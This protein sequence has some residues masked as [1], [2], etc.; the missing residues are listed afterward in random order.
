ME[1]NEHQNEV[2]KKQ[3]IAI[4]TLWFIVLAVCE[5]TGV[6]YKVQR[7]TLME[8]DQNIAVIQIREA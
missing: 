2:A 3:L 5:I 6:H 4:I 8:C 1:R 7:K